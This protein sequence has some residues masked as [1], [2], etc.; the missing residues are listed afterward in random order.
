MESEHTCPE[1]NFTWIA[2]E[3]EECP[4]CALKK[5]EERIKQ[6]KVGETSSLVRDEL[7]RVLGCKQ[8][9]DMIERARH[10]A[11]CYEGAR[12]CLDAPP[13]LATERARADKAE[14]TLVAE[15]AFRTELKQWIEDNSWAEES[16]EEMAVVGYSELLAYIERT[17]DC[18]TLDAV[19]FVRLKVLEFDG[20][21]CG[22]EW[23]DKRGHP[24]IVGYGY[25]YWAAMKPRPMPGDEVVMAILR[26]A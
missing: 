22:L 1:C 6:L 21:V 11:E 9:Q 14:A 17:E 5:A 26:K 23:T 19:E 15:R 24:C 4:R 20:Y 3:P 18:D 25:S 10:L 12:E 2:D 8:G 7:R 13:R 16:P